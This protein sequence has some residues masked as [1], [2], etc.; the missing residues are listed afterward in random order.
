MVENSGFEIS[1]V[2]VVITENRLT[3][4]M[5]NNS[6]RRHRTGGHGRI[7]RIQQYC[8]SVLF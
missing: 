3:R 1:P 2:V 5:I 8:G 6:L 7:Q 4:I